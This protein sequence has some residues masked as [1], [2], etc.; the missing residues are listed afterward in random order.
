[1]RNLIAYHKEWLISKQGK[2]AENAIKRGADHD[3]GCFV[4]CDFVHMASCVQRGEVKQRRAYIIMTKE[5]MVQK[6][7]RFE[8]R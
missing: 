7:Y 8:V 6:V 3:L 5:R 1:M 2:R 4:Y